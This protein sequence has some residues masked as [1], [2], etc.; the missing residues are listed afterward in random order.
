MSIDWFRDLVICIS[1]L[2]VTGVSIFIAVLFYSLYHRTKNILDSMQAR[3]TTMH[4]I[5]SYLGD[6]IITPIIEI[7]ALIQGMR[8]GISAMSKFF[9]K[10]EG[11]KDV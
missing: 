5:S 10:S 8:Q 3:A 11:G 7:V 2:V 9:K 4:G 6:Q 1:G